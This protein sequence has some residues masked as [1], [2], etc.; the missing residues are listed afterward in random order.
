[1]GLVMTDATATAPKFATRRAFRT[2]LNKAHHAERIA[3]RSFTETSPIGCEFG[4]RTYV[5]SVHESARVAWE[6]AKA[7]VTEI[8]A[9][10]KPWNGIA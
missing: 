3:A 6:A 7:R 1:M 5:D 10:G 9:A 4:K 8:F 2:A